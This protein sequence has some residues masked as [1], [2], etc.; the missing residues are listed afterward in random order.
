MTIALIGAG[1]GRTGTS[2]LRLALN[3]IG[4]PTYHMLDLAFGAARARDVAFWSEVQRAPR[5]GSAPNWGETLSE[6]RAVLDYPGCLFWRELM[7]AYPEAKVVLTR[8]PRGSD[9]WYDSTVSTIFTK[10]DTDGSSAYGQ[11][12]NKMMAAHVW[13]GLFEGKFEDRAA[14]IAR[15]EAH[16]QAVVDTVPADRLVIYSVTEGWAPICAALGVDVPDTPFP[17]A[18]DRAEMARRMKMLDRA[19]NLRRPTQPRNGTSG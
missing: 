19:K 6:Y 12:F 13:D 15:Y 1:L 3:Q 4:F 17:Q 2:S 8:H 16:N 7:T 10:P 9:A 11:A 18:N 14:A 5:L